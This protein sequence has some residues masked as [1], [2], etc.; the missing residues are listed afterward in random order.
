MD[1]FFQRLREIQK[2]ERSI[3]GLAKV[4]DNFYK[5]VYN[6]LDKL[7]MKIGN[8]PFSIESYLLRDAR[9][10][11]AEI[12]ERREH[13]IT[14]SAL[15][16]IQRTNGLFNDKLEKFNT[17]LP[18]NLTPEEKKLYLSISKSLIKYRNEMIAPL[19]SMKDNSSGSKIKDI[20]KGQRTNISEDLNKG[21]N[22]KRSLPPGIEHDI[23]NFQAYEQ[24]ES[25]IKE[26][27]GS[28]KETRSIGKEKDI[29][30]T[31]MA[32]EALPS[33][34]GVDNKI[35]GPLSPQ[36]IITM[37]EPNAII[38]INNNKGRFIQKYKKIS[39]K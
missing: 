23:A 36:D 18:P 26:I 20:E 27:K 28:K 21:E 15:L 9:R 39:Y 38:L 19:K 32:L 7:M 10:I 8:N 22:T 17:D 37:P 14:N 3:S 24:P 13:K 16:N 6:Y 31:I 25:F 11:A 4:G 2:K 1:E 33:I 29:I 12:C 5:D 30:K 35:Y 34:M